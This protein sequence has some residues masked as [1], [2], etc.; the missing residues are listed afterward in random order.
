MISSHKRQRPCVI[1]KWGLATISLTRRD[2][3][4]EPFCTTLNTETDLDFCPIPPCVFPENKIRANKHV[5]KIFA[6]IPMDIMDN[7]SNFYLHLK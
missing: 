6:L 5:G 4:T 1:L 2:P 7:R 3:T